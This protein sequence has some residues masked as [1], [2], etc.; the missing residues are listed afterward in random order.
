M[1]RSSFLQEYVAEMSKYTDAPK[2]Y[3]KAV[4]YSIMGSLLSRN[5]CKC[6]LAQGIPHLW[7]N[8]YVVLVGQSGHDRKGTCMNFGLRVLNLVEPQLIAPDDMTPEGLL[9]YLQARAS[10]ESGPS[11]LLFQEEFVNLLLQL[12]RQYSNTLRPLLLALYNVPENYSRGL[13]S[14][15]FGI[16]QPRASLLGGI[17]LDFLAR[18]GAS[19]DWTSGFFNRC[20]F[21]T[22][23]KER[24]QEDP[25]T[26]PDV[27]FERQAKKVA[28]M[29]EA[30]RASREKLKWACYDYAAD[31]KEAR[32]GLKLES[33]NP[34]LHDMLSRS[35]THLT[36]VAALEQFDEDPTARYIGK[37][38]TIR[39]R[40]FIEL[41]QSQIPYLIDNCYARGR[42]DF[43]GD[44]MSRAILRYLDRVSTADTAS[45]L[46]G[47]GLSRLATKNALDA[48]IDAELVTIENTIDKDGGTGIVY[49]RTE[50]RTQYDPSLPQV[51]SGQLPN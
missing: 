15:N 34:Q 46:R 39:A 32:R 33:A 49:K 3:H 9:K 16:P 21:I 42:E 10:S 17:T 31:A 8:L 26:V 48:L 20:L 41:W 6:V 30:W 40:E 7:T 12:K 37:D 24:T 44:R 47:C 23:K 27:L 38:A 11:T 25:P 35:S 2:I 5:F 45:I 36:K 19:D 51:D 22:G 18:H 13:R 14:S 4:G 50:Q 1:A 28:G 29:I 43:E